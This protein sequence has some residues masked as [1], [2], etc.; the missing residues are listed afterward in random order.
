MGGDVREDVIF[1]LFC[2][3]AA[4]LP[5]V[6][7]PLLTGCMQCWKNSLRLWWQNMSCA[8]ALSRRTIFFETWT[9]LKLL[10]S[11]VSSIPIASQSCRL[12]GQYEWF[13]EMS[14]FLPIMPLCI[15]CSFS[16]W[17]CKEKVQSQRNL[18]VKLINSCHWSPSILLQLLTPWR[19]VLREK[20]QGKVGFAG[21]KASSS[22]K[23][24]DFFPL[25]SSLVDPCLTSASKV[26]AFLNLCV[27]KM[28]R[29]FCSNSV[30]WLCFPFDWRILR[31]IFHQ[32]AGS[33]HK[34]FYSHAAQWTLSYL[35]APASWVFVLRIA[36]W[37]GDGMGM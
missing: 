24:R 20:A 10:A 26:S 25:R 6:K 13:M 36:D 1:S 3:V 32:G 15:N 9:F 29:I 4:A 21:W 19:P 28:E 37:R 33:V 23:Q 22:R 27:D 11:F 14:D 8:V 5:H 18:F 17:R 35:F 16:G 30:C 7:I 34:C 12:F 2:D 31:D